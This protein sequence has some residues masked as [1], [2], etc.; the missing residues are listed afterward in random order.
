M[1]GTMYMAVLL[2]IANHCCGITFASTLDNRISS[3]SSD[4]LFVCICDS[5]DQ[6][7]CTN[8]SF[9]HMTKSV[10]PGETFALSVVIVS[11][12]YGLTVG[13]VHAGFLPLHNGSIAASES[14]PILDHKTYQYNQWIGNTSSCTVLMYTVFSEH[15]NHNY[16]MYLTAQYT[17]NLKSLT[18][19]NYWKYCEIYSPL[20]ISVQIVGIL[21][22]TST[23]QSFHVQW[24]SV[25]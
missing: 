6:P 1:V 18:K 2:F 22:S 19:I 7:L 5:K 11:L 14:V 12:E 9:I 20:C 13:I 25:S 17:T 8:T 16:T 23:L 3:A 4:P 24:D 15:I 10:H 21:L